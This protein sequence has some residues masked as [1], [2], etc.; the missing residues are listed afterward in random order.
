MSSGQYKRN[1]ER[2]TADFILVVKAGHS[3]SS[4][5][6]P[7]RHVRRYAPRRKE[8]AS[9]PGTLKRRRQPFASFTG[10]AYLEKELPQCTL[11]R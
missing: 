7:F 4:E 1:G 6:A 11:H 5:E 9:L 8:V 10:C 3:N 2:R